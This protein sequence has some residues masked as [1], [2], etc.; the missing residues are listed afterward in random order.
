VSPFTEYGKQRDALNATGSAIYF[1]MCWGA[2]LQIAS[3]GRAYGNS[4]RIDEVRAR[5]ARNHC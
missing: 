3:Q 2:G 4:W 5:H 1:N